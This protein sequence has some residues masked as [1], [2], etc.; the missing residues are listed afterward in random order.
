MPTLAWNNGDLLADVQ[1]LLKAARYEL[2]GGAGADV[3]VDRVSLTV[4]SDGA[5]S[6][7][8]GTAEELVAFLLSPEMLG[9]GAPSAAPPLDAFEGCLVGIALG[10]AVGLSVEGNNAEVGTE[11]VGKLEADLGAVALPWDQSPWQ[12]AHRERIEAKGKEFINPRPYPLGQI[13][14]DTQC[15]SELALSIVA[16]GRFDVADYA[17]RLAEIHGDT[18]RVFDTMGIVDAT[19]IVGQGPTSKHSLD[20]INEGHSWMTAPRGTKGTSNGSVMRVGPLGLL[21][22]HQPG[23]AIAWADGCL[24]SVITHTQPMC[25]EAAAALSTVVSVAAACSGVA[26]D[27]EVRQRSIAALGAAEHLID[28]AGMLS[29]MLDASSVPDAQRIMREACTAPDPSGAIFAAETAAWAIYAFLRTPS[30]F[31]RT[32]FACIEVG[33]DTDTVAACAG[34]PAGAF[35]GL[36]GITSSRPDA[37]AMLGLLKDATQPGKLDLGGLQA[38]AR[39]LH[40]AVRVTVEAEAEVAEVARL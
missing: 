5:T 34:G 14:D 29:A 25:I 19:G 15:A 31:W 7:S 33:G 16:K 6:S 21:H 1:G 13:S 9:G 10:D 12:I 27:D 22:A 4:T 18:Q 38:L 32:I 23:S 30:D 37:P 17:A 11:Y 20:R 35:I 2:V 39:Q 24:S 3:T 36:E 8:F 26:G 40:D 28:W